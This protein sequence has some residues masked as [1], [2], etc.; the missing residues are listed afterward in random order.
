MENRDSDN[1]NEA[2]YELPRVYG[3]VIPTWTSV[4]LNNLG[5]TAK[6]TQ[7]RHTVGYGSRNSVYMILVL[8]RGGRNL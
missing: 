1:R 3:D 8:P 6:E 5:K 2:N 7:A 4:E